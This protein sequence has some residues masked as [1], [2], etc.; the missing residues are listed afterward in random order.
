MEN[1]VS[2]KIL[3]F[4]K[5][6]RCMD[7]TELTHEK[8]DALPR[9]FTACWSN[10]YTE[11]AMDIIICDEGKW[12]VNFWQWHRENGQHL[13]SWPLP[14][15]FSR[16]ILVIDEDSPDSLHA[17]RYKNITGKC[18]YIIQKLYISSL[19]EC[20]QSSLSAWPDL[21]PQLWPEPVC[22][23]TLT[24]ACLWTRGL[25]IS[26]VF[27]LPERYASTPDHQAL[28]TSSGRNDLQVSLCVRRRFFS[29]THLEITWQLSDQWTRIHHVELKSESLHDFACIKILQLE[30]SES[31]LVPDFC[32]DACVVSKLHWIMHRYRC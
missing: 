23:Q 6:P 9:T 10:N 32:H 5:S 21:S 31:M 11:Y 3:M 17:G 18:I 4:C 14:L 15:N 12:G 25:P 19:T 20:W 30:C 26:S 28:T 22:S 8:C 29:Y 27:S 16:T 13:E 24:G 7:Y 1:Y 2:L